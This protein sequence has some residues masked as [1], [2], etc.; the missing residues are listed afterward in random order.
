MHIL[1]TNDDGIEAPGLLALQRAVASLPHSRLSVVAPP[2][3]QSMCGHS[4][5]THEPI[6]VEQQ[7]PDRWT[8]GSSP[9]DCVRVALFGLGL[10]PD[11]VLSGVNSGGNM[12]QDVVISGTVA[13]AREAAYHG[14]KSIAF[15]HYLIKNIAMDW[16]RVAEWTAAVF[17][18]LKDEPL[19]DGEFWNANFPHHPPGVMPMPALKHCQPARSP[20]NVAYEA[21]EV[22]KARLYR[23]TAS[24]AARPRDAGSDVEVCFGGAIAISKLRLH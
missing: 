20:L 13:A 23:Y 19:T 24:Y 11:W 5:K 16:Q 8:V 14:V 4:V 12:G 22:D 1:L 3:E 10:Q 18:V 9:A 21:S 17:Q 15:S 7:G 6:V 2:W